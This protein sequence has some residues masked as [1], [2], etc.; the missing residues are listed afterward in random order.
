MKTYFI[1]ADVEKENEE[2]PRFL[3]FSQLNERFYLTSCA[4]SALSFD[5]ETLAEAYISKFNTNLETKTKGEI[6]ILRM[7]VVIDD[8]KSIDH[9]NEK[10]A[11]AIAM[12]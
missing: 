3:A 7:R 11:Q 6:K 2:D 12:L 8:P 4:L 5:N 1:L 9:K 10:I